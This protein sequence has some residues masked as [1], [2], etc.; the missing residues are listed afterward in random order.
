MPAEHSF[1]NLT[2]GAVGTKYSRIPCLNLAAR[3]QQPRSSIYIYVSHLPFAVPWPCNARAARMRMF[4]LLLAALLHAPSVR[5]TALN[6]D[7]GQFLAGVYNETSETSI[8]WYSITQF[9]NM[10]AMANVSAG[11]NASWVTF[12]PSLPVAYSLQE[13]GTGAIKAF[14]VHAATYT[15]SALG[16]SQSSGGNYPVHISVHPSGRYLFVANYA[17]SVAVL[18]LRHDG[19]ALP[20]MQV[21]NTGPFAHCVVVSPVS[22]DHVFVVSLANDSVDQYE[23]NRSSGLLSPNPL[24]PTFLLPP[25]TGPRHMLIHP[26]HPMA[27]IADEGNGST[28][29]L[30]TVCAYD[31]SRGTLALIASFSVIPQGSDAKGL[32]PSELIL[33][34][35][36]RF[37]YVSVR[38]AAGTRDSVAVFFVQH[39]TSD[40]LLLA[41]VPVCWYPRSMTLV[42]AH[43]AHLLVVGCQL[44]RKI[45]TFSVDEE[46]GMLQAVGQAV[47]VSDAV[48]F[49][50]DLP[51]ASPAR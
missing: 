41:N 33:S 50:G 21:L 26:R 39:A 44:D 48:A 29:A 4:A 5:A 30:V 2:R 6:F 28:A 14:T 43:A 10:F 46:S 23:F 12:H 35:D 34:R 11:P 8:V 16:A 45:Q 18:P 38:D 27:F 22:S 32:F 40:V 7:K 9:G 19:A 49:V 1:K 17:G 15:M 24:A 31:A 3:H 25:G 37:L 13:T 47:A 42:H 20:P 36:G 51:S